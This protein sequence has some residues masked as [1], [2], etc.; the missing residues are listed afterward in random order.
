M[1]ILENSGTSANGLTVSDMVLIP[2]I[3]IAKPIKIVAILYFFPF[4]TK[5][6][7][8][9]AIIAITGEKLEGLSI[10]IKI[11]SPSIPVREISHA[12]TV[13]PILAPIIT[14]VA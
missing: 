10:L 11:L 7:I 3:S 13:V 9:T 6:S 1:S 8:P 5:V 14:P 12:V 4:L 2:I